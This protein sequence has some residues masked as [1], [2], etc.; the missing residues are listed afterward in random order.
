M[1]KIGLAAAK[2]FLKQATMKVQYLGR[3]AN[4]SWFS[5]DSENLSPFCQRKRRTSNLQLFKFHQKCH[6]LLMSAG[7]FV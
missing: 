6:C 4:D 7:E 3:K 5:V 2:G 1:K